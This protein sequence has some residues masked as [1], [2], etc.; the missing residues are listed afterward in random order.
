LV[1]LIGGNMH[2]HARIAVLFVLALL[3]V[4]PSV[5]RAAEKGYPIPDIAHAKLVF[6]E[7]QIVATAKPAVPVEIKTYKNP[8]GTMFKAYS[9]KDA[10]FRYDV[11]IN[12]EP[13]Y[14][15]MLID[16][17]GDGVFET[18]E[19]LVGKQTEE[20]GGQKYIVAPGPEP[21]K[22]SKYD[23]EKIKRPGMMEQK[24]LLMGYPIYIPA[25]VIL[26]FDIIR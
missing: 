26:R 15:Y 14:E 10:V 8:D 7:T 2:T 9:V 11:D 5:C 4:A 21:G 16:K 24:E 19:E 6:A 12:G 25:W 18:K 22:E 1:I 20:E 23:Y 13:P 3:F 17:D